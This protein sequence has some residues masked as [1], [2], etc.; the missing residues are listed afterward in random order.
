MKAGQRDLSEDGVLFCFFSEQK[1]NEEE[2]KREEERQHRV[3]S[4]HLE[5]SGNMPSTFGR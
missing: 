5:G 3:M 2:Q 4:E 1:L